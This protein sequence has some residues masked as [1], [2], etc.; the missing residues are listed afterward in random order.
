M[1]EDITQLR[2]L[3]AIDLMINKLDAE[4]DVSNAELEKRQ[5]TIDGRKAKIIELQEKIANNEKLRRELEAA[6][7]DELVRIKERQTKLMNVQTNREYQSLL[8]ETEDGKKANKQREDDILKLMEQYESLKKRLEEESA[9]C[10]EEEKALAE[11]SGKVEKS[12]AKLNSKK[13]AIE[14]ERQTKIKDVP[15]N[16]LKKYD[17]LREKRNGLAVVAVTDGICHGCNMNIPPQLYNELLK[18][19]KLLS[20]PTCNRIMFIKPENEE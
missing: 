8:K 5:K 7:E 3:Q 10:E 1:R 19:E 14:K 13:S 18:D 16:L 20:C 6:T 11:E 9:L 15:A 17:L 2:D 12:A 4:M